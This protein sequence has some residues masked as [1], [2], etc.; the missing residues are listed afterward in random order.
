MLV[1]VS[2]GIVNFLPGSWCSVVFWIWDEHNVGNILMFSVLAEQSRTFQLLMLP[3]AREVGRGHSQD[4]GPDRPKR[5]P[6][7]YGVMLSR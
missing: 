4:R 1:L 6:T 5:Y 3:G 7:P 2:A